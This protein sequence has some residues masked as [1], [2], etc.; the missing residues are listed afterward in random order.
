MSYGLN[1][2]GIV[3]DKE[4]LWQE[5]RLRAINNYEEWHNRLEAESKV[6]QAIFDIFRDNKLSDRKAMNFR[7]NNTTKFIELADEMLL[8]V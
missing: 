3:E 1:E 7:N 2:K 8:L 6:N 4:W 5:I